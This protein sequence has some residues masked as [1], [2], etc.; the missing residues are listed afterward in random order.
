MVACIFSFVACGPSAE[1]QAATEAEAAA[2]IEKGADDAAEA[3]E[4]VAED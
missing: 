1:E 2:I 3:I 4:A